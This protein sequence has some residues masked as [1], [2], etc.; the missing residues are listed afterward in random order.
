M[1]CVDAVKIWAAGIIFTA[2]T[3]QKGNRQDNNDNNSL[4]YRNKQRQEAHYQIQRPCVDAVERADVASFPTALT[5]QKGNRQDCLDYSTQNRP[6]T[7]GSLSNMISPALM[8]SKLGPTQHHFHCTNIPKRQET[9]Q[10]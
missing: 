2:L 10:Q 6:Q 8:P 5:S 9:R 3:S 7:R 1:P 4:D